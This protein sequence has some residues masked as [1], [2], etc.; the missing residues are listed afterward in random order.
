MNND[1][2]KRLECS[3]FEALL[4]EA[5][6]GAL[7]TE[8]RESFESHGRSCRVCSPM[9][10]E[11]QEG[12][13]LM[14]SLGELEPPKNLV[15]NIL[16]ATT[17]KEARAE[18][19]A[20]VPVKRGWLDRLRRPSFAGLMHSRFATSFAMAF[21]SLSL[22][23]TLAGV[24]VSEIKNID[25]H[26]SAL[27][28]SVVLGFTQV[29]AK[30]TSYYENLRVVYEVQARV[31]ELKK[32]TTPA[33]EPSN[34]NKQQNRNAAPDDG[35]RPQQQENYSREMDG[36]QIAQFPAKHQGAQI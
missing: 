33:P 9:W 25:W 26:P 17:M 6:D 24:K 2:P 22:T 34:E 12:M 14:R 19:A 7:S 31:Q 27:R 32:K 16:A 30:V 3:E 18:S 11:A 4:A 13:E 36:T 5:L 8:D 28:K 10:A 20:T 1:N 15:H 29:E 35:G 21:F 23:L